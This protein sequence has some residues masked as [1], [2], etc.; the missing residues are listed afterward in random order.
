MKDLGH[1]SGSPRLERK[2]HDPRV[3][4][5]LRSA[6]HPTN[7]RPRMYLP[8]M[9]E[10]LRDPPSSHRRLRKGSV[11][12]CSTSVLLPTPCTSRQFREPPLRER[13]VSQFSYLTKR[14]LSPHTSM[15]RSGSLS[16]VRAGRFCRPL[17]GQPPVG[18]CGIRESLSFAVLTS[19][20]TQGG[21]EGLPRSVRGESLGGAE[22][23][24]GLSSTLPIPRRL[25]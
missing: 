9:S 20:S 12:T 3:V 19:A 14:S 10:N 16:S 23:V 5:S 2:F 25:S 18:H 24:A 7:Q 1:K 22:G 17:F 8:Q 11:P 21:E 4:R 13:R 6:L 15:A